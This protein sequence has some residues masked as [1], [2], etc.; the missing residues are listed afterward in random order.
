L[1]DGLGKHEGGGV[2][3]AAWLIQERDRLRVGA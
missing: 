3:L 1:R 2:R